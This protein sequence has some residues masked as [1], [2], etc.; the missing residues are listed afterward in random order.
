[1]IVKCSSLGFFTQENYTFKTIAVRIKLLR[2]ENPGFLV[3]SSSITKFDT[4]TAMFDYE[5]MIRETCTEPVRN[6]VVK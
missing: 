3:H 4:L 6:D 2:K 5:K 1:M